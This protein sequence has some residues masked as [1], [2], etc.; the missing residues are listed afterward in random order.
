MY[1]IDF[2]FNDH[3]HGNITNTI[4]C[5]SKKLEDIY[6]KAK[7]SFFPPLMECNIYSFKILNILE[8]D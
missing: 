8:L 1:Q 6:K 5:D 4:T 7:N 2:K 3:Y